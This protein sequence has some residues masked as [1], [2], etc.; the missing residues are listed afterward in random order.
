MPF[1]R[2]ILRG[3]QPNKI[4]FAGLE[5]PLIVDFGLETENSDAVLGL[6]FVGCLGK[7]SVERE[8]YCQIKILKYERINFLA[9]Y[10][11]L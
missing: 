5:T 7:T 1:S 4:G 8:S 9:A 3:T 10:R 6:G 2:F 11:N